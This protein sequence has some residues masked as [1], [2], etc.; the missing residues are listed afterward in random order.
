[1]IIRKCD[2]C[3]ATMEA[4]SAEFFF[5]EMEFGPARNRF[6]EFCSTCARTVR[7]FI[8]LETNKPADQASSEDAKGEKR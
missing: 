4:S 3:G 1:M 2:A 5:T 8:E 6:Y 7:N